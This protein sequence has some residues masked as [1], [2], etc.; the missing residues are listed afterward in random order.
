M[1]TL[2]CLLVLAACSHTEKP[3]AAATP[4]TAPAAS[5][6]AAADAGPRAPTHDPRYY[7][8]AGAPDPL[9][10]ANDKDCIGDTVVDPGGCCVVAGDPLPQTWAWH[11]WIT[12][13]RMSQACHDAKCTPVPVPPSMPRACLLEARCVSGVCRNSCDDVPSGQ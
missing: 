3:P 8:E 9:A 10:C 4:S 12:E 11:T 2:L 7:A 5:R 6:P 13:R 1:R